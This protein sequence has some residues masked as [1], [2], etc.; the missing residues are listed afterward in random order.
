MAEELTDEQFNNYGI[1]SDDDLRQLARKL[2]F[3]ISKI[4]FDEDININGG[5]LYGI[6]II[7]LGDE[8]IGGTH[9]TLWFVPKD[10]SGVTYYFDSFGAPP[11][12]HIVEL[13]KRKGKDIIYNNKQIQGYSE[14]HCGIWALLMAKTLFDAKKQDRTKAFDD[15]INAN[16][17]E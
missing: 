5:L 8:Q 1:M 10:R 9:W 3:R 7:N 12:D 11:E 15:F 2:G 17:L 16:A 14:Q 13:S 4:T 6:N